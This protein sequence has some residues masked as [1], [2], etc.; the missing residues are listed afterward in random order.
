MDK[1]VFSSEVQTAYERLQ[2]PLAIFQRIN[3]RVVAIVLSDGFCEL[4]GYENQEQAYLQIN[5]DY[6]RNIH[7]D[8]VE[9]TKAEVSRF[10]K[11][12]GKY[13]TI[14]RYRSDNESAYRVIRAVGKHVKMENGVTLVHIWYT[15]ESKDEDL[16]IAELQESVSSLL[17][18][19]PAMTF[20]KDVITGK[21]M[22]CNQAFADYAHKE[23]PEGVVGLTD[24]EIFDYITAE[25]FVEDDKK[26]LSMEKPFIFFEDVPDAAGNMRR[27]Q[28][29]KLKFVD[30]SG[31]ECLLGLCQDVT[32]AMQIKQEYDKMLASAQSKAHVDALT[33]IRNKT[34]YLELE[35]KMDKKIKEGRQQEFAITVFDVNNLKEINDTMGHQAGDDYI[36]KACKIICK[37]YNHSPVFRVGG[38]EFVA[39]SEGE[40]Y[41]HIDE[42]IEFFGGHNKQASTSGGIVIACGM[43]RYTDEED[44]ASL[45]RIADKKMYENKSFLKRN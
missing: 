41:E 43:A 2:H 16:K 24:F 30:A 36:C 15:D 21:Y 38:D 44:M 28:T 20:S 4:F 19:M 26:A 9:R 10:S 25:H 23:T 5:H 22:A 32:E 29:T 27:F 35:A 17:A 12:G 40:D 6:L 14:Y 37:K 8:D 34:A 7:H 31:R 11:E 18:N 42:L 13:D 3:N 33:G 45:F 1:Y 39:I